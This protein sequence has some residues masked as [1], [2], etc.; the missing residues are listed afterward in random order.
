MHAKKTGWLIV[1]LVIVL[2]CGQLLAQDA[3]R[4]HSRVI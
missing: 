4:A 1:G 2:C 3:Q